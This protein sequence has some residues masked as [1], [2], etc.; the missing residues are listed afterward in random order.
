MGGNMGASYNG[1]EAWIRWSPYFRGLSYCVFDPPPTR[2]VRIFIIIDMQSRRLIT[3]TPAPSLIPRMK[4][5]RQDPKAYAVAVYNLV[6]FII[7][8]NGSS[9]HHQ[10]YVGGKLRSFCLTQETVVCC[11]HRRGLQLGGSIINNSTYMQERTAHDTRPWTQEEVRL[12]CCDYMTSLFSKHLPL[13][14]VGVF[15]N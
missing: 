13:H 5:I 11:R 1:M 9:V 14:H 10:K 2:R 3:S 8:K 6:V 12:V 4:Y 15:C 7:L